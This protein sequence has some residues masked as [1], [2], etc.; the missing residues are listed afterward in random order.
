M[1]LISENTLEPDNLNFKKSNCFQLHWCVHLNECWHICL[2]RVIRKSYFIIM[3]RLIWAWPGNGYQFKPRVYMRVASKFACLLQNT[4]CQ[5]YMCVYY[6]SVKP[7]HSFILQNEKSSYYSHLNWWFGD[8]TQRCRHAF[9]QCCE[10]GHLSDVIFYSFDWHLFCL[11]VFFVF[12]SFFFFLWKECYFFKENVVTSKYMFA[13]SMFGK[14]INITTALGK[15]FKKPKV[16]GNFI[17]YD[18]CD[19]FRFAHNGHVNK[20]LIMSFQ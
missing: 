15:L 14:L 9:C 4:D 17:T 19:K 11:V 16:A 13:C 8:W 12:C 3:L 10:S 7:K 2:D 18:W 1:F 20:W 5:E 6:K